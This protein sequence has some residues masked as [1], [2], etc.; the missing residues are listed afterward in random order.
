MHFNERISRLNS[1]VNSRSCS[2]FYYANISDLRVS[3][4]F[5][6]CLFQVSFFSN[7]HFNFKLSP[8]SWQLKEIKFAFFALWLFIARDAKAFASLNDL[9][10][11]LRA[12]NAF[13]ARHFS[14][15]KLRC[16]SDFDWL[17]SATQ[18]QSEA[19]NKSEF[20]AANQKPRKQ[21]SKK[22]QIFSTLHTNFTLQNFSIFEACKLNFRRTK[23]KMRQLNLRSICDIQK[24]FRDWVW[25]K[26]NLS[27]L[28][29]IK[30]NS[31]T[32]AASF[33]LREIAT[34]KFASVNKNSQNYCLYWAE[35][36]FFILCCSLFRLATSGFAP[37]C[38]SPL[39][40]QATSNREFEFRARLVF[41]GRARS[42]LCMLLRLFWCCF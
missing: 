9:H 20:L 10:F 3:R 7:S 34:R 23:L 25:K 22:K 39:F 28:A 30:L 5:L 41:V 1:F 29:K 15:A 14:H 6:E 26:A 24:S 40:A 21:K 11:N 38:S 27:K 18:T 42:K 12:Q 32:I 19:K 35:S 2:L 31:K 16:S 13:F 33:R 8:N 17:S 4:A 36:R 37:I